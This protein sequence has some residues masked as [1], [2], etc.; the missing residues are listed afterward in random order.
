MVTLYSG[1]SSSWP[2]LRTA[3]ELK[4][5]PISSSAGTGET[6]PALLK[7]SLALLWPLS[8]QLLTVTG[9]TKPSGLAVASVPPAA[10][11]HGWTKPS[12]LA[13]A[14][15]P[16]ATH[17]HGMDQAFWP[18]CGL[19]PTSCS[20]TRGGPSLAV[21]S[22]PP[23]AHCH[24][25]D[26]ALLWPLSHQLLTVTGSTKP[27][28][29]AVASVPPAAHCHGVD[30]ALLWPLSH[31]L[32]TVTGSTKPSGLAVAS[33]PPA[34]H[35]H[36]VDQAF[37]PCCGLCP[38][39]CSLSRGGPSL[40]A[41]LWPLS[42]QLLTVT[43]WTKPSGLA[44]ASVPPAAHCHGVDQ[45]FWPCC[46][47]C[48]TSCSLS[49]GRPSLLALLW[50]LSHQLL[51]VTGWTKPS[52]LAVASV[53]PAAHCHG[54][55]QALLWPLSHQLLTVT[56]WTKPSGLAVASV[57]PAA[58]CHGIDQ[59]FW[60]CCGLCPT[61]CSLSRDGPSLLALLWPL[62]HQLLTVTGWTKPCCGLCPT[63]CSLSRGGPSLAV[64]SVPP[65]AHCHGVDQAFWPC[66]GLCPTSYSLSRDGPSLLALLWPL[67]H[68]LLTVTGWTKPSG[69]AVASVPPAAHCH[70]M[71]QALL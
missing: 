61:S 39:S 62:S 27:S 4:P 1:Y 34:A 50:P 40:L 19:C 43:G 33:V 59:A 21:A 3:I 57:P 30:Q 68:Q 32:L 22:V 15:V 23:A 54:V 20:L 5:D 9:W 11:C 60:P 48:P 2:I 6:L 36:G 67:S 41:L 70:G 66:C 10:H 14:S 18:C 47:L 26:Q 25:V 44:V 37:W 71:D 38:T 55:D 69:L 53:P 63:S 49:R 51:T 52:G 16:P 42:H 31:Q 28:G 12:G 58:H 65:A 46:G 24:G 13:V 45:A 7:V 8:H 35:C 29:L 56:G 17:C 64:A